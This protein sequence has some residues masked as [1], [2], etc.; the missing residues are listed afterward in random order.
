MI[1]RIEDA[2][3]RIDVATRKRVDDMTRMEQ[4][5]DVLRDRMTQ[6]ITTLDTVLAAA[7][8]ANAAEAEAEGDGD[9][10]GEGDEDRTV[11]KGGDA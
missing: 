6:A 9:A 3:T 11:D 10:E 5:H 4:R 1:D 7:D 2:L 8:A